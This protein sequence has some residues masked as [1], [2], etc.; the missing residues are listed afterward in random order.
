[1]F[2]Q[3]RTRV[4]IPEHLMK[5]PADS[6]GASAPR[7]RSQ[8]SNKKGK[9][10]GGLKN[11]QEQQA[12][13]AERKKMVNAERIIHEWFTEIKANLEKDDDADF[14]DSIRIKV[15][16]YKEKDQSKKLIQYLFN[17]SMALTNDQKIDQSY[18]TKEEFAKFLKACKKEAVLQDDMTQMFNLLSKKPGT[19]NAKAANFAQLKAKAMKNNDLSF[20]EEVQQP[21][22]DLKVIQDRYEAFKRA[23]ESLSGVLNSKVIKQ[24]FTDFRKTMEVWKERQQFRNR[25]KRNY[26]KNKQSIRDRLDKAQNEFTFEVDI[27][28]KTLEIYTAFHEDLEARIKAEKVINNFL[29]DLPQTGVIIEPSEIDRHIQ[30]KKRKFDEESKVLSEFV[31]AVKTECVMD[32]TFFSFFEIPDLIVRKKY[33]RENYDKVKKLILKVKASYLKQKAE[34]RRAEAEKKDGKSFKVDDDVS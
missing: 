25:M 10:K 13:E 15:R 14:N 7:P 26:L 29:S 19:Q 23:Q 6:F 32:Q 2:K 9:L 16:T 31:S 22:M 17:D 8:S 3:D 1:M 34:A 21:K 28:Q 11:A 12:R 18:I 24:R 4:E 20:E 33:T 5:A 30:T 27:I